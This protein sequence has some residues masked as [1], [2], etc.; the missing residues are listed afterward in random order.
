M[1]QA[2]LIQKSEK[3]T[4]ISWKIG[5]LCPVEELMVFTNSLILVYTFD[6][7]V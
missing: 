1:G 5:Y 3:S 2:Q 6:F 7:A 4:I